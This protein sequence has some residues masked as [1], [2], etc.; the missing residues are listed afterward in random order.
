MRGVQSRI[1]VA[2]HTAPPLSYAVLGVYI[3]DLA[4]PE[5]PLVGS[6]PFGGAQTI[7]QMEVKVALVTASVGLM[8]RS[9]VSQSLTLKART[10]PLHYSPTKARGCLAGK[11][12]DLGDIDIGVGAIM[13][14][15]GFEH[16]PEVTQFVA[17]TSD[18]AVPSE[19]AIL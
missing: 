17:I 10:D 8:H 7:H 16:P 6:D 5:F 2:N 18:I 13:P 12:N 19:F 9:N 3:P 4:D 15:D 14:L 1:D 11:F